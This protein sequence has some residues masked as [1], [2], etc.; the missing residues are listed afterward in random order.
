[1]TSKNTEERLIALEK[2]VA[3]LDIDYRDKY[4]LTNDR[5]TE[6]FDIYRMIERKLDED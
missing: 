1:M 6:L 4:I 2:L 3:R 5:I